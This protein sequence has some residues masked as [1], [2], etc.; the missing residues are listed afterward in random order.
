MLIVSKLRLTRALMLYDVLQSGDAP[1]H[2]D[3]STAA[4]VKFRD[5][6]KR[7]TRDKKVSKY[8]CNGAHITEIT[9]LMTK[10]ALEMTVL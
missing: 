7:L 6:A 1:G 3:A 9:A 2:S 10:S 5:A 8:S 4:R